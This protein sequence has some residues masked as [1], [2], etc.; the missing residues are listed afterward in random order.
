MEMKWRHSSSSGASAEREL[1]IFWLVIFLKL[2][3]GNDSN[4]KP[5]QTVCVK[6]GSL[7]GKSDVGLDIC[8]FHVRCFVCSV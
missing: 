4:G 2:Q 6:E 3:Q 7:H 8:G 5:L 1:G